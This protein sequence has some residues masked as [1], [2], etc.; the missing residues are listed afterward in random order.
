MPSIDIG[1]RLS[2]VAHIRPVYMHNPRVILLAKRIIILT[3]QILLYFFLL[4]SP[5]FLLT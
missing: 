2:H 4:T 3:L 1:S 5:S